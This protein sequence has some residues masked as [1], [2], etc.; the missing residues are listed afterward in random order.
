M[1]P[2]DTRFKARPTVYNG[3]RMRSRLEAGYAAWLDRWNFD[4]EYEPCAFQDDTGRQY[5][6]DF[7]LNNVRVA[8]ANEPR[9]VYVEVK[10]GLE[11]PDALSDA[12]TSLAMEVILAS[13]PDALLLLEH[14]RL[15]DEKDQWWMSSG[16]MEPCAPTHCFWPMNAS[17]TTDS[18][19]RSL[20]LARPVSVAYGPWH[21]EWWKGV[22]R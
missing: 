12:I 10:P 20:I 8:W 1:S 4:W 5:L 11:D 13:E 6:P 14:P 19:Y 9:T 17:W 18:F 15:S 22:P 7:R 2:N 3:I 16:L 21:G